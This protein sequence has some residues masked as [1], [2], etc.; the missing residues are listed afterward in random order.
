MA[1]PKKNQIQGP[2]QLLAYP[3]PLRGLCQAHDFGRVH[4]LNVCVPL[5]FL[6]GNS[7]FQKWGFPGGSVVKN[8][9]ANAEDIGDAGSIPGSRRYP[10]VGNGNPF[11][12]LAWKIPLTEKPGGL[13]SIGLQRVG[14]D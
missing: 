1:W 11:S 6:C 7:K 12:T 8:P 13:Q 14:H 2:G 10:G 5:K 3:G 4:D 9:P